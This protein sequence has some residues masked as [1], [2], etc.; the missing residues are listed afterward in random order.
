MI[1]QY[2]LIGAS[3]NLDIFKPMCI[4]Q[5][6]E[7]G[8]KNVYMYMYIEYICFNMIGLYLRM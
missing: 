1:I 5:W 4:Y 7:Q 3:N 8:F 2:M 6:I